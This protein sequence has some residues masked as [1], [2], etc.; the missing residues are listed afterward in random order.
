MTHVDAALAT[1]D[2][3]AQAFTIGG[4]RRALT[5]RL[6]V[7]GFNT[8]ELDARI[9]VGHALSLFH[10]ALVEAD[11]RPLAAAE[12]GEIAALERRRLAHEPVARIVGIKEFWSL[13]LSV[14]AATLVPRP[15]TETAVE[16]ALGVVGAGKARAKPLRIADLG[17]GTGALLLAL[18]SELPNAFGVGTDTSVGALQ[19]AR[20]NAQRLRLYRAHFVDCDMAAALGGSFDLIVSNPPYI[21]S[22]DIAALD[23]EVRDYDPHAA[24]DGGP[25]G[26]ACYRAIAATVPALL[27][28]GGALVVELGAGQAPAVS[29]LLS[30][31][32]L[33]PA[34]ACNDLS[35]VPRALVAKKA[36]EGGTLH[37]RQKSTWN[38]DW[39]RLACGY[40]IGPEMIAPRRLQECPS[41]RGVPPTRLAAQAS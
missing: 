40:G 24:L 19:V 35:G 7:A 28:L 17:T 11:A 41:E 39:N 6:R 4:A 36:H 12:K 33:A 1:H 31:A 25:D 5:Q 29:A 22:G 20:A 3:D 14:T 26:L 13:P 37:P 23:A 15:E 21:A 16:A 8:P 30:A 10:V 9:L 38:I 32:G 27:K 2:D 18:L 34:P